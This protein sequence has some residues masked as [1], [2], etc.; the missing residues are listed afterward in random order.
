MDSLAL[1]LTSAPQQCLAV[2]TPTATTLLEVS[3]TLHLS[4][5]FFWV[6]FE[7]KTV[8]AE[9]VSIQVVFPQK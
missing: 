4:N 3:R 5:L 6:G 1:M 9:K 2:A 8:N 7:K